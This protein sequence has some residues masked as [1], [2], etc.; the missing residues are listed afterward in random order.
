M[1]GRTF[2][3]QVVLAEGE[4]LN[5]CFYRCYIVVQDS[6]RFYDCTFVDCLIE[7]RPK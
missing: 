4:Y 3:D 6:G 5:C 1:I 7:N 2:E